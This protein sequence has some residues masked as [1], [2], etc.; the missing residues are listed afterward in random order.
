MTHSLTGKRPVTG[1]S[2]CW[3]RSGPGS[4][5]GLFQTSSVAPFLR[6]DSHYLL[7]K[8]HY[9]YIQYNIV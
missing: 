1:T 9:C 7:D 3:P 2:P 8:G 5:T 6:K 4:R